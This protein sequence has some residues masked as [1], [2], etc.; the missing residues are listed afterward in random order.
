M[1]DRLV[2][3]REIDGDP[4]EIYQ[5]SA[6]VPNAA[7]S[8]F[9]TPTVVEC[10]FVLP[11]PNWPRVRVRSRRGLARLAFALGRRTGTRLDPRSTNPRFTAAFRVDCDE[12]DFA[13]TLL[14]PSL[15]QHI[16][17]KRSVDWSAGEGAIKLFYRGRLRT[18]RINQA[19]HRLKV[20]RDLIDPELYTI[21]ADA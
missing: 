18:K 1:N 9:P 8:M 17:T 21:F 14:T 3:T 5:R 19:L 6:M 16:L 11:A 4:V 7:L 13:S 12:P 2:T 20:F 15:Q 10:F